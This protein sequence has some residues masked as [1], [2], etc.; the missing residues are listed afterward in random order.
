MQSA[1]SQA[2]RI[3]VTGGGRITPIAVLIAEQE[4]RAGLKNAAVQENKQMATTPVTPILTADDFILSV[5]QQN[6]KISSTWACAHN[7]T[8]LLNGYNLAFANY[9]I[10]VDA[11]RVEP[12]DKNSPLYQAPPVPPMAYNL[13]DTGGGWFFPV[14]GNTPV[15]APAPVPASQIGTAH[16][17]P[18][19]QAQD[20]Y[21][22]TNRPMA[23]GETPNNPPIGTKITDP[24][25]GMWQKVGNPTPFGIWAAW[26]KIN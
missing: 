4:A 25:G 22:M 10:S 8:E 2:R 3:A 20:L 24:S 19:Q 12:A 21:L 11:G 5:A 23:P 18:D 14:Q 13:T 7:N 26:V 9:K 6:Q 16:K 15:C 1:D 17:T